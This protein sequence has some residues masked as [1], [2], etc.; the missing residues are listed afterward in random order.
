MTASMYERPCFKLFYAPLC[1]ANS[2]FELFYA[3]LCSANSCFKFFLPCLHLANPCFELFYAPRIYTIRCSI[4][5][6]KASAC[7]WFIIRK[8]SVKIVPLQQTA[9]LNYKPI[10][11]SA[12]GRINFSSKHII[13]FDA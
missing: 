9:P 11:C 8:Y 6:N 3:P 12:G 5:N 7:Y 4:Y 13:N 10:Q 2:C 1:S